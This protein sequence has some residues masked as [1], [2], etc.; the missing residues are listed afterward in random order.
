MS[1]SPPSW[2]HFAPSCAG[3]NTEASLQRSSHERSARRSGWPEVGRLCA[4]LGVPLATSVSPRPVNTKWCMIGKTFSYCVE[5]PGKPWRALCLSNLHA[6]GQSQANFLRD[7]RCRR[8]LLRWQQR[9]SAAGGKR[10]RD[11]RHQRDRRRPRRSWAVDGRWVRRRRYGLQRVP[12]PSK[13]ARWDQAHL[14]MTESTKQGLSK[15]AT[16]R[17]R[18]AA[19]APWTRLASSEVLPGLE[20]SR[21]HAPQSSIARPHHWLTTHTAEPPTTSQLPCLQSALLKHPSG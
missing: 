10:W 2:Q 11:R 1:N 20:I 17:L 8:M 7:T 5:S 15:P 9:F 21:S 12:V 16:Y 4:V 19:L 13:R 18:K 3:R 14:L 6:T